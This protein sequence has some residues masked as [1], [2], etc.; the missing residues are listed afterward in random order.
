[1]Q[2]L[3]KERVIFLNSILSEFAILKEKSLK[4]QMSVFENLNKLSNSKISTDYF[5]DF[6]NSMFS[7]IFSSYLL[8]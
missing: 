8:F 6:V 4:S 7:L 3:E 2:A 5:K 1:M